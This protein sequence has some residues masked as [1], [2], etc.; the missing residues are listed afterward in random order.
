M[1]HKNSISF[2]MCSSWVINTAFNLCAICQYIIQNFDSFECIIIKLWLSSHHFNG[3]LHPKILYNNKQN[4]EY[5]WHK[6]ERGPS[7]MKFVLEITHS[8]WMDMSQG[9]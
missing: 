7:F 4:K 8:F 5:E 9:W 1:P 6:Y 3:I 2:R